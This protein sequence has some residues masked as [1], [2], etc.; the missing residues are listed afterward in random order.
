MPGPEPKVSQAELL[1]EIRLL[2]DPVVTAKEITERVDLE[3]ATVNR[4]LDDLVESGYLKEK[5]VGASAVVY[6]MTEQGR[7]KASTA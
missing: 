4:K 1:Q 7:E 2:P 3:N 5:K 6:W